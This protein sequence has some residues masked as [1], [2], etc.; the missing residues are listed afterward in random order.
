MDKDQEHL[1]LLTVF[2]YVMGG[3][4]ALFACFPFIHVI[5]GIVALAL[6]ETL[7]SENE[8]FPA[9]FGWVFIIMGGAFILAGWTVATCMLLAGRCLARR[10]RYTF[11]MVIAAIEC[12]F[13]PLGTVLGVFTITIL[14]R[15]SVKQLFGLTPPPAPPQAEQ[16]TGQ[17][18]T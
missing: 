6:P 18:A 9:L 13:V 17:K 2:H 14:M 3:M 16:Q 12:L 8:A 10:I 1:Q 7:G 5:L 4:V 11:C 15:P